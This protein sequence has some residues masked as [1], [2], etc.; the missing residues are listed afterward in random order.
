[1]NGR[2]TEWTDAATSGSP[3]DEHM[4]AEEKHNHYL[5]RSIDEPKSDAGDFTKSATYVWR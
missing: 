2:E 1:M 5:G 4:R 3:A